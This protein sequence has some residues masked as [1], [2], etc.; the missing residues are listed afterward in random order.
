MNSVETWDYQ[1]SVE[2]VKPMVINWRNLTVELVDELHRAHEKLSKR[3]A[4]KSLNDDR[5]R[6]W[7][8]YLGDVGLAKETVRGWLERYEP[9]EHRLLEPEEVE[10][11]KRIAD[12]AAMD[13]AAAQRKRVLEAINTGDRTSD[14]DEATERAYY[15]ELKE[16]EARTER[17]DSAKAEMEEARRKRDEEQRRKQEARDSWKQTDEMLRDALE[18]SS[19]ATTKRRE[20]KERIR[21]SQSGE[22]DLFIEALM[23][24]LE[25]LED[26]SRRIEACQNIIKVCRNIATELQRV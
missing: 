17:I 20:F 7:S 18:R 16:R 19:E 1:A 24:Y 8:G 23:D 9:D 4:L 13:K 26:D 2:R 5:I 22:S 21:L 6:S 10:E 25:E 15:R 12:R 3:G 11:R 14:W